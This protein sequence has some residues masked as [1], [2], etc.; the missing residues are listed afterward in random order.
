MIDEISRTESITVPMCLREDVSEG[1]THEI[2][3][4]LA[5]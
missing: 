5:Y 3:F 1:L 2:L 4:V